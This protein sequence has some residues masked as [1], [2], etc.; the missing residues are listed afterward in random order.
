MTQSKFTLERSYKSEHVL[1]AQR[2]ARLPRGCL[3][4]RPRGSSR[5]TAPK[6]RGAGQTNRP[7]HY[8]QFCAKWV[9]TFSARGC[10]RQHK[11]WGGA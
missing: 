2:R 6:G 4:S 3:I 8:P 7:S 11:A 10:G 1:S 5:C 9:F